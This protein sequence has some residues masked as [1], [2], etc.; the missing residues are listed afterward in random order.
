MGRYEEEKQKK[1]HLKPKGFV[2]TAEVKTFSAPR[3]PES[4][5]WRYTEAV[6]AIKNQ[7]QCG[8]CWAFS[9]TEAIESQMILGTG[10]KLAISLAPQQ[11]ASCA[12]STG[13]YGCMG[14]NGGFTEGAYEYVKSAPG[15]ANSFFIPYGQSLT[16][17]VAT[18]AC[19]TAKVKQ[20]NGEYA[21]L[22][23]GYA[24]VT[25]YKYAV[26]PCTSG[27]VRTRISKASRRHWN[28]TLCRFA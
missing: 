21:Q 6:T 22:Q 27:A 20:I 4:I 16:E 10:G 2:P 28:N 25:G 26:T 11:I 23:G 17:S 13:T 14:C 18:L 5:N 7:G 1:G 15:L 9:A 19:P 12:P 3:S 8:S 24:Q